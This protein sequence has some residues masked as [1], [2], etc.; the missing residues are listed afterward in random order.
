M[1]AKRPAGPAYIPARFAFAKFPQRMTL[2]QPLLEYRRRPR[3]QLP[4][5]DHRRQI[6]RCQRPLRVVLT[7][8]LFSAA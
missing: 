3:Q 1:A 5:P 2:L 4:I 6:I 8:R 7:Q